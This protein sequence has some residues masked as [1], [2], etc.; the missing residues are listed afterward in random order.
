MFFSGDQFKHVKDGVD[1]SPEAVAEALAYSDNKQQAL[2]LNSFHDALY[3]ACDDSLVKFGMQL[4]SVAP[5]LKP[6]CE[7][8]HAF[9]ARAVEQGYWERFRNNPIAKGDED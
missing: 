6:E 5:L 8:F 4:L 1:I 9:L 2:F 7:S 3:H